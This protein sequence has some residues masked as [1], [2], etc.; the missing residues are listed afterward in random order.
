MNSE[1]LTRVKVGILVVLI[2]AMLVIAGCQQKKNQT[3]PSTQRGALAWDYPGQ[4]ALIVN[5]DTVSVQDSLR[6]VQY[7]YQAAAMDMRLYELQSIL[8][9]EYFW[10]CHDRCIKRRCTSGD[11]AAAAVTYLFENRPDSAIRIIQLVDREISG[12]ALEINDIMMVTNLLAENKFEN[13]WPRPYKDGVIKTPT[14]LAIWAIITMNKGASPKEWIGSLTRAL[15]TSNA[16]SLKY[17]FAYALIKTG[18]PL[19]AW[20]TL[21]VYIPNSDSFPPCDF[22][23]GLPN[24]DTSA[25]SRINLTTGLYVIAE[26]E[27]ALLATTIANYPDSYSNELFKIVVLAHMKGIET[28][29]EKYYKYVETAKTKSD[30]LSLAVGLISDKDANLDK[31]LIK[32]TD[33]LARSIYFYGVTDNENNQNAHLNQLIFSEI[34]KIGSIPNAEPRILLTMALNKMLTPSEVLARIGSLYSS[35]TSFANDSPEWLALY[36]AN[37]TGDE[38]KSERLA[39]IGGKLK[40]NYPYASGTETL[41]AKLNRLCGH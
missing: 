17:A 15:K 13:D 33:P 30:Q 23:Q 4:F 11:I 26:V 38:T 2:G 34:D 36:A 39:N 29:S 40:Q 21:P 5:S 41:I 12:E 19:I 9:R 32:L 10:G 18:K 16:P 31:Q 8:T 6:L 27:R 20:Q 28:D 35:D 24:G 14:G 3:A 25:I 1:K 7:L 22:T 37:C